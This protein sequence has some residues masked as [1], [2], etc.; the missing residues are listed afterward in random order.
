VV[1][2]DNG[3]KTQFTAIWMRQSGKVLGSGSKEKDGRG[4]CPWGWLRSRQAGEV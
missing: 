1:S 3:M 2:I 4:E